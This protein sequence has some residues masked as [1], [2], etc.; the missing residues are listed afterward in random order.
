MNSSEK[1]NVIKKTKKAKAPVICNPG[2]FEVEKH[3]YTK[4][5]W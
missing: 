5:L 4:V 1:E 2:S 3:F